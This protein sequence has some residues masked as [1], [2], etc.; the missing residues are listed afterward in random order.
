M[1]SCT[2]R[3]RVSRGVLVHLPE[4]G[5]V[6]AELAVAHD[7]ADDAARLGADDEARAARCSAR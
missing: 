7:L 1:A 3:V 4:A 5:V 6:D 2:A